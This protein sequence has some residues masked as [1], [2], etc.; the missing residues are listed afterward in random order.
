MTRI[1]FNKCFKHQL[2][3]AKYLNQQH[4]NKFGDTKT[5]TML[6]NIKKNGREFDRSA[7]IIEDDCL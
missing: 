4:T 6:Q 7:Y 2:Y 3:H 5:T 1:G